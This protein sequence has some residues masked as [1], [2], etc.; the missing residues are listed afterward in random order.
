[1]KRKVEE[2]IVPILQSRMQISTALHMFLKKDI[3]KNW[4]ISPATAHRYLSPEYREKSRSYRQPYDP[5]YIKSCHECGKPVPTHKRC[6]DCTIL[7][8]T[9]PARCTNCID[10]LIRKKMGA[11]ET[12]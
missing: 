11:L 1:M 8:H 5:S 6:R 9:A 3:A 10:T 2:E 4:T 7:L 12:N